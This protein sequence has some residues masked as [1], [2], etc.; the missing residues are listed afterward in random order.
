M[1]AFRRVATRVG[2]LVAAV[3]GGALLVVFHRPLFLVAAVLL[4][5]VAIVV[6]HDDWRA[7]RDR[8]AFEARY[9]ASG[10]R[11]ILVTSRSPNWQSYI[12]EHWL[13]KY[14]DL[15]VVLDWSER[16]H[17]P[18]GAGAPPEVALFRRH[19]GRRDF[20]PLAIGVPRGGKVRVV[21]FHQAFRDF[22]HGHN[23]ALR[24]AERELEALANELRGLTR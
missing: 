5:Y 19:G 13:P 3:A 23:D 6:A 20:N 16:S 4:V 22:K 2:C 15:A 9:G 1:K 24:V 14:A 11:L 17:W 7:R 21:R 10:R 12:A 18:G 8:R